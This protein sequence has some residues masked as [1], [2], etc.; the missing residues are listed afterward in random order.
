MRRIRPIFSAAADFPSRFSSRWT[1]LCAGRRAIVLATATGFVPVLFGLHFQPLFAQAAA[2]IGVATSDDWGALYFL[3][4]IEFPLLVAVLL[5]I[6]FLAALV[7]P[8]ARGADQG[9]ASGHRARLSIFGTVFALLAFVLVLSPPMILYGAAGPPRAFG[10]DSFEWPRGPYIRLALAT[11]FGF[12]AHI[13]ARRYPV[14]QDRGF[15]LVPLLLAP[16]PAAWW[17]VAATLSPARWWSIA[18]PVFL[19]A[20]AAIPLVAIAAHQ[21]SFPIE[22]P[23]EIGRT[24]REA[25]LVNT[26]VPH[27]VAP[28]CEDSYQVRPLPR[29]N[30]VLLK[31]LHAIDFV[32][33]IDGR[34]YREPFVRYPGFQWDEAAYDFENRRAYVY[35]G[36]ANVLHVVDLNTAREVGTHRFSRKETFIPY[37][38]TL[39]LALMPAHGL[40]AVTHRREASIALIDLARGAAIDARILS[41]RHDELWRVIW[42][43]KRDELLVLKTRR[44]MALSPRDLSTIRSVKLPDN[45]YEM[46]YDARRDRLLIGY[47]RL[48]RVSAY[49]PST[50]EEIASADAPVGAR[51][52]A[53]DDANDLVFVSS[54]TG[55]IET[56]RGE[57]LSFVGRRRL[58][59]WIRGMAPVPAARTMIVTSGRV[60][61]VAWDY[62]AGDDPFDPADAVLR[63]AERAGRY[64]I[65]SGW[66]DRLAPD[67]RRVRGGGRP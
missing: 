1:G 50:F 18:R 64:A 28:R 54:A 65:A 21:P 5:G 13:A 66:L 24:P 9:D 11:A 33:E 57:D 46:T 42:D 27:Q 61:P 55:V 49:D 10:G 62:L 44:L 47:A 17:I 12:A 29:T 35:D 39:R 53:I 38:E 4:W 26:N 63:L 43:E 59:P 3:T 2:E 15:W 19:A 22:N 23:F 20:G 32:R 14:S 45:A 7:V 16:A 51:A 30:D 41:E 31:C 56:R 52:I 60:P 48:M 6:A 67:W 34:W 40:L 37:A 36:A 25:L 8:A 58:V